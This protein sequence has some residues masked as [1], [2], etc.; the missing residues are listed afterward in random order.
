MAETGGIY[1]F[2]VSLVYI[3]IPG[4]P[5]KSGFKIKQSKKEIVFDTI[6]V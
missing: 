6:A 1:E 4:Q 2:D 3:R 5:V